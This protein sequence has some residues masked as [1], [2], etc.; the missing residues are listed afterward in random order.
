MVHK[1]RQAVLEFFEHNANRYAANYRKDRHSFHTYFF[2]ERLD[3][4]TA[5][6]DFNNKNILDIGAGT[7]ALFDFIMPNWPKCTY[8]ATDIS[9]NML[10]QSNIP[11]ENQ[12]IGSLENLNLPK[13]HFDFVFLLGVTSYL[14]K[15][16]LD[17]QL[18][19]IR[20]LLKENGRLVI[21]FT[22][23][24]SLD[25]W[26]RKLLQK[27]VPKGIDGN[28]LHQ[29]FSIQAYSMSDIKDLF[30][31]KSFSVEDEKWQNHTVT[32]FNQLLPKLSIHAAKS[33]K[34]WLPKPL[35][36]W[37]SADFTVVAS[38]SH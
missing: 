6:Y 9:G 17:V 21:S 34:K 22:N 1:Q 10:A 24:K 37:L 5:G 32:P 2:M 33:M 15:A 14:Q 29:K 18:A 16:E 20:E 23:Y 11:V 26:T 31:Q 36:A 38:L 19:I 25:F 8:F 30:K 28:L 4:A 35:L 27:F 12:Y 13:G 7:G 3:G